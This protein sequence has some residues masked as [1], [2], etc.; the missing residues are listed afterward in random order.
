MNYSKSSKSGGSG[1]SVVSNSTSGKYSMKSQWES[2][3]EEMAKI[4]TAIRKSGLKKKC[5]P[6]DI[7]K[8]LKASFVDNYDDIF[9][10]LDIHK[11]TSIFTFYFLFPIITCTYY[12]F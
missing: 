6:E 11:I 8:D 12:N 4:Y 9:K 7:L 2:C 10:D 3:I 1:G 5:P